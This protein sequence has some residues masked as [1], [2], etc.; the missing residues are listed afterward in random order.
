[1]RKIKL[2]VLVKEFNPY[3]GASNALFNILNEFNLSEFEIH[4]FA[5][6]IPKKSDFFTY[7]IPV[8][9]I[10]KWTNVLSYPLFLKFKF[11]PAKFDVIFSNIYTFENVDIFRSGGGC[12]LHFLECKKKYGL[13]SK[14]LF[15]DYMPNQIVK[16]YLEKKT[17]KSN[18]LKKIITN[19]ET[20]KNEYIK[21]YNINPDKIKILH[22]GKLDYPDFLENEIESLKFK[23]NISKGEFVI[24]FVGSG[25][26]TKGLIYLIK[27]CKIL[28]EKFNFNNFKI[29]II[30]KDHKISYY[31]NFANKIKVSKNIL[32]LGAQSPVY[33]YYK[34]ANVFVI[35]SMFEAFSN[36][37]IEAY[38]YK[39]PI[40]TSRNNGFVDVMKSN[41][42]FI[43][44]RPDDVEKLAEII[45]K[46][47]EQK[48]QFNFDYKFLS[49]KE[50]SKIFSDEIKALSKK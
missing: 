29:I 21:N 10:F 37:C 11:N 5:S 12:H 27:A 6:K 40:I 2:A 46:I 19:F 41:S 9:K 36:A 43:L 49:M 13:F 1:M 47:Y 14:G 18:Q 30:G 22:N 26:E 50:Y 8:I 33:I 31:K 39:V 17:L 3:S 24:L 4:I 42:D 38:S 7:K 23:L 16:K 35:P 28:K 32:F 45:F 15:L 34:I 25:Y 44:E 48:I 20:G